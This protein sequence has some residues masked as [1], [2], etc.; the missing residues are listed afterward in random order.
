VRRRAR[1]FFFDAE[2]F[3]LALEVAAGRCAELAV[4]VFAGAFFAGKLFAGVFF[5]AGLFFADAAE[6][7]GF[8]VFLVAGGDEAAP[9][10]WPAGA[11]ATGL[12]ADHSRQVTTTATQ[13]RVFLFSIASRSNHRLRSGLRSPALEGHSSTLSRVLGLLRVTQRREPLEAHLLSRSFVLRSRS[14]RRTKV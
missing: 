4:A 8:A 14:D 12:P 1:G 13:T 3:L 6:V 5:A 10:A 7:A 11:C 2:D 9:A